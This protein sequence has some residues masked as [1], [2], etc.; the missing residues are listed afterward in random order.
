M[1][2]QPATVLHNLTPLQPAADS[3]MEQIADREPEPGDY[4]ADRDGIGFG[5]NLRLIAL[6]MAGDRFR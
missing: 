2:I 4:F 6:A 5:T 3:G 1:R